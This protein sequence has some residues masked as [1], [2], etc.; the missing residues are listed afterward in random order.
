MLYTPQMNPGIAD[1]ICAVLNDEEYDEA[2][3]LGFIYANKEGNLPAQRFFAL[4][5]KIG[6]AL[7]SHTKYPIRYRSIIR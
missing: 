6:V 2:V 5:R 3:K 1:L 7:P 4:D